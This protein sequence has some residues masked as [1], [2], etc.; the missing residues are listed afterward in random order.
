MRIDLIYHYRELLLSDQECEEILKGKRPEGL[1]VY[2]CERADG[3][4]KLFYV[5]P[6]SITYKPGD[7]AYSPKME[8]YEVYA[9]MTGL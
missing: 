9:N 5:N 8:K 7:L 3:K 1:N 2:E 6:E 4:G